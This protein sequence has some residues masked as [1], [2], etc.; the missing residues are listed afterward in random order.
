MIVR[1]ILQLELKTVEKKQFFLFYVHRALSLA[2]YFVK[3]ENGSTR[4]IWWESDDAHQI[5]FTNPEAAK[6]FSTRIAVL[7][8]DP[9]VDGFKF[10]AG[11]TDYAIPPSLYEN[12]DPEEV[13]NCLT[14]HYVKTCAEFGDLIEVRSAWR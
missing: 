8:E 3:N 12:M 14:I 10:D 1:I 6:W 4:A 11:E 13:P 7:K 9:G 2:G 5:D